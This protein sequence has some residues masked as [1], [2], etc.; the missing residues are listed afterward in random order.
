MKNLIKLNII[1]LVSF[2]IFSSK[3]VAAER[4]LPLPKPKVDQETK[5]KTAEKKHIYP[6]KKP[7]LKK[8]K[9]EITESK[10]VS[11][12]DEEV[13][14]EVFIYPEKKPIIFHKKTDKAAA[15]SAILSSSDFKIAKASFKAIK[16]KKWQTAIKLSK[17][18]KNKMV[19][20]MV[21]WLYLIQPGNSA[22]FYDYLTF[23]NNNP[24][25]PRINRLKYL[26]EHKIYLNTVSPKVIKKWF[27]GKEPLS[28]YGKIKLGEIYVMENNIEEGSR[29]IKEGWI[30]ARLSKSDLKYLRKKYKK[31]NYCIR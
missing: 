26:A 7:T 2:I 16:K 9:I 5:I 14:E 15:K 24:N 27:N 19:F 13:K 20:K 29:L 31:N 4:I 17:K 23:I 12:I 10:E 3:S 11:K 8:E 18:A 21:N 1:L 30:K 22:T 28:E 6:K 25:Y